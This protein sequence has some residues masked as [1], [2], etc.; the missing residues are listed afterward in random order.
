MIRHSSP[1]RL[2][3]A[4]AIVIGISAVPIAQV[5][6]CSCIAL[7]P[8]EAAQMADV[9]FAGSVVGEEVGPAD[10]AAPMAAPVR[11][12][13]AVDGVAKG[14][15]GA[16]VAVVAGGDSA[17]CGMTF[18][19]NERW[20]VF[21]TVQD[22]SLTTGVCSGNVPLQPDEDPPMA[23][24]LPETSDGASAGGLPTGVLLPIAA[25]VAIGGASA[26]LFW[27]ADR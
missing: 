8:E 23:L 22:G 21:G 25:V 5:A 15:V 7:G 9:V 16:E 11:Y 26:L 19:M 4:I 18:A 10:P 20:L 14:E 2:L 27:R 12:T 1:L 17:M 24:Y 13:F 3:A 6:A